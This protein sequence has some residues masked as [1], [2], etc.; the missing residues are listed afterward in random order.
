M[1][2]EPKEKST[3]KDLVLRLKPDVLRS[4]PNWRPRESSVMLL[5]KPPEKKLKSEPFNVNKSW[6]NLD[7]NVRLRPLLPKRKLR[8]A[9]SSMKDLSRKPVLREKLDWLRLELKPR[10][11]DSLMKKKLRDKELRRRPDTKPG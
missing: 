3:G 5:L 4:K 7:L 2:G 6:S 1:L 8:P 9:D 11:E 10:L